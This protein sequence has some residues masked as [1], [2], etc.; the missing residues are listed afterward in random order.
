MDI[1]D[2]KILR[3]CLKVSE[4]RSVSQ[5]ALALNVAQPW[6]STRI[7]DYERRLG[8]DIFDRSHRKIGLTAEGLEFLEA[9]RAFL[10]SADRFTV[11]VEAIRAHS[12]ETVLNIG[13]L[14][15]ASA[16]A[17][18]NKLIEAFQRKF[19]NVS[20]R[21][22]LLGAPQIQ[23]GLELGRLDIAFMDSPIPRE[24]R[25]N[26]IIKLEPLRAVLFMPED[27]GYAK[28]RA[29]SLAELRGRNFAV[30]PAAHHPDLC[31]P[32]YETLRNAGI[33][34]N[35]MP[36]DSLMGLQDFVV[37]KGIGA[38]VVNRFAEYLSKISGYGVWR[39]KDDPFSSDLCLM[40]PLPASPRVANEFWRFA[41]ERVGADSIPPTK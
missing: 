22:H 30:T 19:P 37:R 31:L 23:L 7:R 28:D 6:L 15:S 27:W 9:G 3:Q 8:F 41:C 18:R 36:D 5:A 35:E 2:S 39:I 25:T 10:N 40:E 32:V 16:S 24:L 20:V 21:I 26:G 33:L 29:I 38:I 14:P 4:L 11:A 34:L 1:T 13:S 17:E 12:L